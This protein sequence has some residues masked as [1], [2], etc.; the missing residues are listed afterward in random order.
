MKIT[1][2]GAS[3]FLGKHVMRCFSDLGVNV[4]YIYR[5]NDKPEIFEGHTGVKLDLTHPSRC[6]FKDLGSPDV[7]LHLAWAGLPNYNSDHHL[8]KELPTQFHF[9]EK[10][11]KQGLN[12][13][14]VAGTCFEYGMQEGALRADTETYPST[15]YG[16]AKDTLRKQLSILK[17]RNNFD[18]IWARLFYM[19]GPG[20]SESSLF[21]SIIRS[22]KNNEPT[23]KMSSG[24][25]KRDFLPVEEVAK[26]LVDIT[27]NAT[28][29]NLINICSGRPRSVKSLVESWISLYG[30]DIQIDYGFYPI[31][32]Y[33]PLAFW[34]DDETPTIDFE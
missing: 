1:V 13:L 28:G 25:Q 34:G 4:T 33:E 10:M 7:L 27:L 22:V 32:N 18:L 24:E 6:V 5:G 8:N 9:L 14:V 23:F 11:V 31:P 3:G 29:S 20:Q 2:T 21:P 17:D 12:G 19:Y 26:R 15:N 16:I 30:W